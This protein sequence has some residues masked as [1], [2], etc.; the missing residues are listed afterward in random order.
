MKDRYQEL[1]CEETSEEL[2][3]VTQNSVSDSGY[4]NLPAVSA[5]E[6]AE[7]LSVYTDKDGNKAPIPTGWTV[8]G[9]E[10]ENTIW[11]KGVSLVI[12]R[13]SKGIAKNVKWEISEE[14]E[15]LKKT[16]EQLVWCPVEKLQANGTLDGVNN[17]EK[18]GRRSRKCHIPPE[19]KP[20]EPLEGELLEQ[21]ESIKKYGGFYIS[22]YNISKGEKRGPHSVKGAMPWTKIKYHEA[23]VVAAGF[24]RNESATSHLPYGAEY[25]SV[26]RW[27]VDSGA[28]TY[29]EIYHDSSKW[30]NYW[31][32]EAP[33]DRVLETGSHEEWS[34]NNLHDLAG[35][36]DEWTQEQCGE[37]F[38]AIRGG[39]CKVMGEYFPVCYVRYNYSSSSYNDTGFRVAVCIK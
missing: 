17:T 29:D 9:A 31:E 3:S 13:V 8:S 35:N 10:K 6:C 1:V 26:L 27:L 30:G 7:K 4:P 18:F 12:Y 23:K 11:G 28:K 14:L 20:E 25:D 19:R 5:G 36:V 22:R 38:H 21:I 16:H 32:K 15:V 37:M 33:I 24:M 39:Y 34:A 2:H